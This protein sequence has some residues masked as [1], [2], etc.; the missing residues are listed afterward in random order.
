LGRFSSTPH[1]TKDGARHA[2]GVHGKDEELKIEITDMPDV[3]NLSDDINE[4]GG[5]QQTAVVE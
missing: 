1:S 5:I 4:V 2:H 3:L